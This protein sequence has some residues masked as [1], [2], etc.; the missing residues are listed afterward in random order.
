MAFPIESVHRR[1]NNV[2]NDSQHQ[3]E[4]KW[5][6]A[7]QLYQKAL[8]DQSVQTAEQLREERTYSTPPDS[9]AGF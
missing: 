9:L 4:M 3:L 6:E 5:I 1:Y 2:A 7:Q 8:D